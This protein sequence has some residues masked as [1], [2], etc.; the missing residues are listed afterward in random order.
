[1]TYIYNEN[2]FL[3]EVAIKD[4]LHEVIEQPDSPAPYSDDLD[5]EEADAGQ[6]P[7]I[8]KIKIKRKKEPSKPKAT[9]KHE[10][11]PCTFGDCMKKFYVKR[12]YEGHMRQHNGLKAAVCT[13]CGKQFAKWI[14]HDQHVDAG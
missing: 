14:S 6:L 2:P 10:C 5:E 7:K 1:L 3:S 13:F 9:V 4:E 12:R 11:F 8:K